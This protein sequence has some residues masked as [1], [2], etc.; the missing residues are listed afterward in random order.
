M[1]ILSAMQWVPDKTMVRLQ[2]LLQT[3]RRLRLKNP[4]S[5]NEK[6]QAYKL[7]YRDPVMLACTDKLEVRKYVK[8]KGLEEILVPLHQVAEGWEEIDFEK[9]PEKFAIK[10][11][12]GG[13]GHEVIVCPD[14][15]ALNK[16]DFLKT[17]RGWM[18]AP[19]PKK[20]IAREWAYQNGLPRRILVEQILEDPVDPSK[21]IDDFKFFCFNG[22]YKIMQLHKDRRGNH[23]AGFWDENLNFIENVNILYPTFDKDVP[24]LPDNIKEMVEVAEKL[25]KGFPYVRVDLYNIGGKI[26]FSELTFYPASGYIPFNPYSFDL[27]L[28]TYFPYPF[29]TS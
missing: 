9:L 4:E 1:M 5:F 23:K 2:F 8:D 19:K 22:K 21:D 28:G 16:E 6:M 12:D 24:K 20:H 27:R 18:E 11:S 13:G 7:F 29:K 26:Y 10:T 15:K 3:G 14:K 17:L 25:S